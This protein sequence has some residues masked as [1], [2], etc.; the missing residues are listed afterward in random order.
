MLH[1]QWNPGTGA[2]VSSASAP[3]SM[4]TAGHRTDGVQEPRRE[5]A[6]DRWTAVEDVI[7]MMAETDILAMA[8]PLDEAFFRDPRNYLA[9]GGFVLFLND[10]THNPR[11]LNK[12]A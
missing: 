12:D 3:T 2:V 5:T 9:V 1:G 8:M 7:I 11:N 6:Q 10:E 4:K